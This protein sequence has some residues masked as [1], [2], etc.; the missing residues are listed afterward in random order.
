MRS[1]ERR[2]V[3]MELVGVL[4]FKEKEMEEHPIKMDEKRDPSEV[5]R[6]IGKLGGYK[7]SGKRE[8]QERKCHQ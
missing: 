6:R 4:T 2:G 8:C 3:R 1:K 7:S 5:R